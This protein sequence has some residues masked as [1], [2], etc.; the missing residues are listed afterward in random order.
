MKRICC[1]W[2][3]LYCFI[4][5]FSQAVLPFETLIYRMQID[6][7][8]LSISICSDAQFLENDEMLSPGY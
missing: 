4:R 3:H 6:K 8:K 1:F 7:E 5:L 2:I